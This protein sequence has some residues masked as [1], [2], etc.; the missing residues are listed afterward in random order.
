MEAIY[1]FETPG[2]SPKYA[3]PDSLLPTLLVLCII[4]TNSFALVETYCFLRCEAV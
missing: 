2:L 1:F 3:E 4:I